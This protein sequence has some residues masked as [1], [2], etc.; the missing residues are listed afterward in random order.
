MDKI[1]DKL[2]NIGIDAVLALLQALLILIIG[3]KVSKWI[4]KIFKKN[5]KQP[6]CYNIKV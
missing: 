2:S 5:H 4:V 1:I 3:L 6:I